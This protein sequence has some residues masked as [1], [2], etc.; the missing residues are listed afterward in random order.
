MTTAAALLI[1]HGPCATRTPRQ[2]ESIPSG[3]THSA[4]IHTQSRS[5]ADGPKFG[6]GGH[7]RI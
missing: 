4:H 6:L 5:G 2:F 3:P 1:L 7:P